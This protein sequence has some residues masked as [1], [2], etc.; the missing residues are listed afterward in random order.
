MPKNNGFNA[1]TGAPLLI[2]T[3][4]ESTKFINVQNN[5]ASNTLVVGFSEASTTAT[6]G[7]LIRAGETYPVPLDGVSG[8]LYALGLVGIIPSVLVRG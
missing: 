6:D 1:P 8:A 4:N 3:F 2:L 7:M 5:D